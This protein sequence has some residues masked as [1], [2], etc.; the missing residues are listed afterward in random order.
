M[1]HRGMQVC[2]VAKE[3]KCTEDDLICF[4]H[5]KT[6]YKYIKTTAIS[7]ESYNLAGKHFLNNPRYIYRLKT[8]Y[9]VAKE[10]KCSENDLLWF[11]S[12]LVKLK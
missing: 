8:V 12:K 7:E 1:Y 5:N 4:L 6:G 10:F 9:E 2:E 11:L 3:F